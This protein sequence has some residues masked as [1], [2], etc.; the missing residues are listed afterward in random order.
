MRKMNITLHLD[1][2]DFDSEVPGT[3]AIIAIEPTKANLEKV[4]RELG[5]GIAKDA[6]IY[7][8]GLM[9]PAEQEACISQLVKL[10]GDEAGCVRALQQKNLSFIAL[11]TNLFSL[12]AD[13]R[14]VHDQRQLERSF[15]SMVKLLKLNPVFVVQNDL[16]AKSFVEGIAKVT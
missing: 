5:R 16:K 6:F 1:V 8:V 7:L 9:G 2:E 11:N 13:L 12:G 10:I 14:P 15:I 4:G 3:N